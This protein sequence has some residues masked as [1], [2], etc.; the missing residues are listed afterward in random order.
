MEDLYN[1]QNN[2]CFINSL[3]PKLYT[4]SSR[5]KVPH[6]IHVHIAGIDLIR[7]AKGEFYVLEDNL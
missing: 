3:L 1:G 4:G 5:I 7:G 6:N 2:P